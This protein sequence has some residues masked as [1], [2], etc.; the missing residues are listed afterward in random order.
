MPKPYEAKTGI[1]VRDISIEATGAVSFG[2]GWRLMELEIRHAPN[3]HGSC[4]LVT[5]LPVEDCKKFVEQATFNDKVKINVGNGSEKQLIFLGSIVSADGENLWDKGRL[6]VEL[7]DTS[8]SSDMKK[9]S[10]SYQDTKKKYKDILTDAFGS[11]GTVKLKDSLNNDIGKMVLRIEET[12][13]E[14]AKR[15]AS[16]FNVPVMSDITAEKSS[17]FVGLPDG[18][19]EISI[20]TSRVEHYIDAQSFEQ[21]SKNSWSKKQSATREDFSGLRVESYSYLYLGDKIKLN[22]TSYFV[23]KVFAKIVGGVLRATYDLAPK[24]AGFVAPSVKNPVCAGRIFTAQVKEVKKD[25]VRVHL[26]DVDDKFD[27]SGD[28]WL[29]YATAYSS[30]DGSGWYVMPEKDDY[31]RVL[32]PTDEESDAY[33]SSAINTAPTEEV[34]NKSFKAPGGKELLLT[35][36]GVE[37]IAEHQKIFVKLDKGKGIQL[38]STKNIEVSA[39]GDISLDAK[40]NVQILAKSGIDLQAGGSHLKVLSDQVSMGGNSIKLG[41]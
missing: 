36:D 34:R 28:T 7:A 16:R 26:I 2:T 4:R 21:V 12:S 35:D 10:R 15:I 41:E 30:R 20:D 17:V 23:R 39:D 9:E 8:I 6:T 14:F 5:E 13:W 24:E 27:N 37:I 1:P 3:E 40:G 31:V 25:Q 33:V 18:G 32:F 11:D 38:V 19:G 29:P 22:G